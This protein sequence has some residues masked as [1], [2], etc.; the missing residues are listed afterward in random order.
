MYEDVI[1]PNNEEEY[2]YMGSYQKPVY[3]C[4]PCGLRLTTGNNKE[5]EPCP[6]CGKLI[7]MELIPITFTQSMNNAT[8]VSC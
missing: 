6:M 1:S 3:N 7:K 2:Y 4:T 5:T 8:A